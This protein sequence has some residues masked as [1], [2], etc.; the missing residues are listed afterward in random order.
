VTISTEIANYYGASRY[1]NSQFGVYRDR[2]VKVGI[3]GV[4]NGWGLF[5]MHGN[6]S[7]WCEDD[8][9]NSYGRPGAPV[10]GTPWVDSPRA[11]FR[12]FRGG[13]WVDH[14]VFLRAADRRSYLPGYRTDGLGFR[15][16]RT[17]P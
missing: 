16:V 4:A 2:A 12:M 6:V 5:D 10:N 17:L 15:L 8:Y 9:H 3:L 7:E 11:A 1:G 14:A 13:G